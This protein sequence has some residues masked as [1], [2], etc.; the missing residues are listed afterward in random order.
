MHFALEDAYGYFDGPAV[1][2]PLLSERAR[3][4]RDQHV[5]LYEEIVGIAE[6]AEEAWSRCPS[7]EEELDGPVRKRLVGRC[8]VFWIRLQRHEAAEGELISMA[9]SHSSPLVFAS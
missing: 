7:P 9:G 4:L 6:A 3:R 1:V 8:R 2:S 5:Q